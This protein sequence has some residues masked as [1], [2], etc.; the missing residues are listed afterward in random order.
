MNRREFLAS[1]F[2]STVAGSALEQAPSSPIN[3]RTTP[4]VLTGAD[5]VYKGMFSVGRDTNHGGVLQRKGYSRGNLAGRRVNGELRLFITGS[6][7]DE[8]RSPIYEMTPPAESSWVNTYGA[9]APGMNIVRDWSEGTRGAAAPL[10]PNGQPVHDVNGRTVK[11]LLWDPELNGLWYSYLAVY[12]VGPTHDPSIGFIR[13]ND[14]TSRA[15]GYGPWRHRQIS[16]RT[17]GYGLYI[18]DRWKAMFGGCNL[19]FGAETAT[20]G[21]L[22]MSLH[23]TTRPADVASL[24]PD[25]AGNYY[26][27]T[28]GPGSQGPHWSLDG[29]PALMNGY[30]N[31]FRRPGN[32][33]NC[34]WA[35]TSG[36]RSAPAQ[37]SNP[38]Y[39]SAPSPDSNGDVP[40]DAID[41]VSSSV[42]VDTGKKY[43]IV[44][45]GVLVWPSDD[46]PTPHS[47]Y[48]PEGNIVGDTTRTACGHGQV[49][50]TGNSGTGYYASALAPFWWIYD[51]AEVSK[52]YNGQLQP[53]HVRP[54]HF[55]EARAMHGAANIAHFKAPT[56][57]Y[58]TGA[59]FDPV[60]SY[61]YLAEDAGRGWQDGEIRSMIHVFRVA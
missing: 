25:E 31:P 17:G 33:V 27:V 23:P 34:G 12:N 51:P 54:K 59:Y 18:P 35:S 49:C 7:A 55:F 16:P 21:V 36:V 44:M 43:G 56:R 53:H 47:W 6:H 46:Y 28:A 30:G 52:G 5:F 11:G 22:G 48:G 50:P 2:A 61:L 29:K 26:N 40:M 24:P 19:A 9:I 13:L 42:F 60:D 38:A 1:A 37:P 14:A 32:F 41:T 45:F 20:R 8:W 15:T 10:Y 58:V 39:T 3:L 4:P 57:W